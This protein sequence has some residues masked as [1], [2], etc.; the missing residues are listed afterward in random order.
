[1]I[2]CLH[3]GDEIDSS[4]AEEIE[5]RWHNRCIKSFFSTTTLPKLDITKSKLEK[6][7][8]LNV[9]EGLT[10]PGVQK[11]IS[12]HLSHDDPVRLTLINYPTGYILKPQ[13]DEYKNLPEFEWLAMR[14]ASI[15]GIKVVPFALY[16][17]GEELVYLTKRI[18]RQ[19][20]S[21]NEIERFAMEDFCQLSER[22]VEDKYKGSYES[23]ARIIKK[24]SYNPRLDLSELYLRLI[25]SFIIGNSDL[26][27][28]N[29]SLIESSPGERYFTLSP[30]YDILPV[31]VVEP[32][33]PDEL[34]LSLNGK[35]R[36]LELEDFLLFAEYCELGRSTGE[37]IIKTVLEKSERYEK[38]IQSSPL[39][40][41][42]KEKFSALISSRSSR[43]KL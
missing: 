23:C 41:S 17:T 10:I 20:K 5:N 34:A 18:D 8:G 35:K 42:E 21:E 9:N 43:L 33:D 38:L 3:C 11:K 13:T 37:K 39:T 40:R 7:V 30:A 19:F 16:N 24:Y 6:L 25:V 1:M 26:H 29:F 27:L 22:L 14:L 15:S 32:R 4:S 36:D 12:L 31:N 2:R 28:K